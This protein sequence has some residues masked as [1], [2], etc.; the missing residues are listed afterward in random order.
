MID[1]NMLTEEEFK[2]LPLVIEGESKEVRYAGNGLVVIRFKPTIYS[3]TANRCGI[4]FGS[5]VLRLCATRIFLEVFR[6][7]GIRH[8]YKEIND[9]W[10]LASL[11]MPTNVEFKKYGIEPFVIPSMIYKICNPRN[12]LFNVKNIG[13][14]ERAGLFL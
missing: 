12:D 6:R 4:V 14:I 8:A 7:A 3:Y 13:Q 2:A 9:R 5:D 1:I 11:V 10:V